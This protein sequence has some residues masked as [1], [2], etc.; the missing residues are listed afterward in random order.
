MSSPGLTERC[1]LADLGDALPGVLAAVRERAALDTDVTHLMA[2]LPAL[3]RA[4]RYGD[5]AA[6]TR[7]GSVRWQS[8]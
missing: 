4:A 6:P 7:P 1:L 3:V 2:A 8:R 5:C